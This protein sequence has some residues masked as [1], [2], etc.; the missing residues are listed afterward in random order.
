MNSEVEKWFI[1]SRFDS[2]TIIDLLKK[3][4]IL[5]PTDINAFN[6]YFLYRHRGA[7]LARLCDM[8]G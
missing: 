5:N 6:R 4:T 7:W 3:N 1:Q 8:L 2:I